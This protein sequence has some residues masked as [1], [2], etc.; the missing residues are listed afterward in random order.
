[1]IVITDAAVPSHPVPLLAAVPFMV[2]LAPQPDSAVMNGVE[3]C[4]AEEDDEEDTAAAEAEVLLPGT[5]VDELTHAA[6]D[7]EDGRGGRAD[8]EGD[9]EDGATGAK[10]EDEEEADGA[11]G[12]AEEDEEDEDWPATRQISSAST[13]TTR[14]S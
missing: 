8:E 14:S 11:G 4:I 6:A 2:A 5:A 7:D 13:A 1:M 10:E 9:E 12:R 3:K